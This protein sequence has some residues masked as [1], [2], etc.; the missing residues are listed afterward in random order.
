METLFE[1][2]RT[3]ALFLVFF[4]PGFISLKIYDLFVPSERRDFSKSL[5]DAVA[6]SSLNFVAMFWL[7]AL[8]RPGLMCSWLWYLSL[9]LVCIIVPS[10]WPMGVLW[11]RKH[12]RVAAHIPAPISGVWDAIF[13]QRRQYWVII[14]LKDQRRIGG[15]Y[16]TRSFSSSSPASP[17]IFLEEVWKLSEAGVF[18]EPVESSAGILVLGE[19]IL[20]LEFFRYDEVKEIVHVQQPREAE[21]EPK[22]I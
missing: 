10:I 18:L 17:Q 3:L 9:L 13:A 16:S 8:M 1:S 22:S 12:P 21:P 11:A 2:E 15:V 7:I 14:H 20:G 6:Y 5:F 19:E 4:V